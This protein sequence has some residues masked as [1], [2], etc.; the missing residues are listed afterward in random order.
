PGIDVRAECYRFLSYGIQSETL[1]ILRYVA[2]NAYV[3]LLRLEKAKFF[4]SEISI[5]CGDQLF[6]KLS[7]GDVTRMSRRCHTS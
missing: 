7:P 2:D 1:K 3:N 5:Q 6:K 4:H